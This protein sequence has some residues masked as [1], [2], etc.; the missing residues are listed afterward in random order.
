MGIRMIAV[1]LDGTLLGAGGRVG[2]RNAA[3]LLAAEEAGIVVAIATGRRHGYALRV[4]REVGLRDDTILVSSNG[5]IVRNF[6]S[7]LIERTLMPTGTA[8][9]LCGVLNDFRN[10]LVIT[11]DRVGP[12]GEDS[13]GALV[14]EEFDALH[15]SIGHWMINNDPFGR[16]RLVEPHRISVARPQH[17]RHPARRMLQGLRPTAGSGRPRLRRR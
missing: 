7:T 9:W 16:S 12:D 11:F 14:V 15:E 13:K 8:Q 2:A 3:A 10:A 4:L 1:D 17:R 6:D 5:A